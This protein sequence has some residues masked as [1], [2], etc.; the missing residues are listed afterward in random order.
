MPDFPD[1]VSEPTTAVDRAVALLSD[2]E[3][4]AR[5]V[6]QECAIHRWDA[7]QAF[8]IDY[9]VDGEIACEGLTDFFLLAWPM[10]LDYL[11]RPAGEGE[12]LLVTEVDGAGQWHVVLG[13]RATLSDESP[14]HAVEVRGTAS[15]LVLWLWG[16]MEPPHVSGDRSV[17]ERMRNPAGRFLSPGF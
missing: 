4:D 15:D 13:E 10:L 3:Q 9:A 11:K 5:N 14:S 7:S 16:R 12:V 6:S 2:A 8:G 17:L 1:D